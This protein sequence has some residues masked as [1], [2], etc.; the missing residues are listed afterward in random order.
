MAAVLP[1]GPPLAPT[2]QASLLLAAP[3]RLLLACQARYGDLFTL[4]AAGFGTFVV[5]AGPEEVR[6]VFTA[7][8]DV[9]RAGESN[10]PLGA[11][12]GPRSI[13]LLDGAEH[14]QRRKLLLP[15][16]HGERMR[17]WERAMERAAR[18]EAESWPRG[19]PF[20]LLPSMQEITLEVIVRAVF[21][22]RDAPRQDELSAR[23]RAALAPVGSR[24]RVL[25]S[26]LSGGAIGDGTSPRELAS[27]VAA[28]DELLYAEIADRRRAP[29]LASR[30][31]V[32][33]LLLC[34]RDEA[35]RPLTDAEVRDEL[36]TL[37]VAGHETTATALAWAFALLLRHPEV[38][39]EL[40]RT[41]ADGD[42]RYLEAVVRETLRLRPVVPNVGRVVARE[43]AIGPYVLP[44][45]VSVLPSISLLHRRAASFPD[46]DAFRPERFL[47]TR[48]DGYA[49][50]PFGGGTRRCLGASFAEFEMRTV[51]RSVLGEARLRATAGREEGAA[52]RGIVLAP[53]HGALAV[54]A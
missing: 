2:L 34:A 21:G 53:E 24:L 6:A 27:R 31:D 32:L 38:L 37:L 42:E 10:Q 48:P 26:V 54:A 11:L 40:E 3:L 44:P 52:R 30:D 4:R 39:G 46:P 15:P 20:A 50:I 19:R 25:V 9:L 36:M 16:F 7:P 18:R 8:P 22:V 51:I 43:W 29:H 13:L 47:E 17:A 49:W 14:L 35:G 1:P 45:G 33:S 41:L 12:L 5:A 23:L 28:V